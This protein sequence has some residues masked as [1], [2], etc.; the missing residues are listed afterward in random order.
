MVCLCSLN[1]PPGPERFIL[2]PPGLLVKQDCNFFRW[3]TG[4]SQ[5]GWPSK[6]AFK[7]VGF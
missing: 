6:Q 3:G 5:Q 1:L 4:G 2:L 7:V